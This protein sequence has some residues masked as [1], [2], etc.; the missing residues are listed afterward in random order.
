MSR[1]YDAK[2]SALK[3]YPEDRESGVDLFFDILNVSAADFQYEEG[4]SAEE[5]IYGSALPQ[6]TFDTAVG[7]LLDR[8]EM[9]PNDLKEELR[10]HG[11]GKQLD[12][13]S[14][15]VEARKAGA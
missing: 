1:Q 5:Y 15:I 13:L 8:W 12:A 3:A 2:Q 4:V 10:E 9:T 14:A 7:N 6:A 11:C